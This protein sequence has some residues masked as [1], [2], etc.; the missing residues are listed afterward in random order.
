MKKI[1][2]LCLIF[3]ILIFLIAIFIMGNVYAAFSCKAIIEIPKTQ[4]NKNEEF[5]ID[6]NLY[7]V[8]SD[9]GIIS[10]GATLQ[11]DKDSLTLVKMQGENGWETPSS[12]NSYNEQ[13]GKIAITRNGVGKNDETVLRM[14]FKVKEGSKQNAIVTLKDIQVADGQQLIEIGEVHKNITVVSPTVNDINTNTSTNTNK[15]VATNK[16]VKNTTKDGVLP[17]AGNNNSILTIFIFVV[18]ISTVFLFVK[19]NIVNDKMKD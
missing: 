7:N 5:T 3:S 11:Y 13:N 10:L 19:F 8:Q 4:F 17:K 1:V 2:K 16:V 9:R 14:T 12:A 15:N 18:V 6:F